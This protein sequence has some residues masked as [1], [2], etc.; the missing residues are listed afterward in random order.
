MTYEIRK[1]VVHHSSAL[2]F[3]GFIG[4]LIY[5]LQTATG[6]LKKPCHFSLFLRPSITKSCAN[7]DYFL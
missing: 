7:C 5:F 4:A 1:K 2:Y 6:V 3:F